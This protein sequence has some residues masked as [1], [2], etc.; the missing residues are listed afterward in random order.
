[1][2]PT[3]RCLTVALV[4]L[5][6]ALAPAGFSFQS[7]I[8]KP[9]LAIFF[10]FPSPMPLSLTLSPGGE[11][12]KHGAGDRPRTGYLN[13]GKVALYQVSYARAPGN[14]TFRPRPRP[15]GPPRPRPSARAVNTRRR[16]DPRG[17]G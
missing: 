9:P 11:R 1:M 4:T 12:E 2:S 6:P 14:L 7:A 3:Y 15:E 5:A 16:G 8:S 17:R 10:K 13:L